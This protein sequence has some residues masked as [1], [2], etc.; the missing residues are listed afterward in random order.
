MS[1][2]RALFAKHNLRC[3]RQRVAVYEALCEC[4]CHPTAEELFRI[5]KPRTDKLS[6]ATVYNALEALCG[7][8][9]VQ[10]MPTTNGSC[11]YDADTSEH[12]HVRYPET[13]EI[14]DVPRELGN[15]LIE[16]LPQDVLEEIE[17]EMGI[18]I[19]WV[20]VQLLASRRIDPSN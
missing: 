9:L 17:S 14:D 16:R 11:R 6:L 5:V 8:E 4:K 19:D 12:P 18:R 20:S 3:T 1:D 10:R 15:K 13:A 2:T 7:A